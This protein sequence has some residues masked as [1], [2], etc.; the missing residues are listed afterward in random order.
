MTEQQINHAIAEACG[1]KPKRQTKLT[2]TGHFK[3]SYENPPDYCSDLNAMHD[4][5]KVLNTIEQGYYWDHL[6]DL[7]DEGFDQLHATAHQ[8]AE[9]F[10]LTLGKWS[11]TNKDFLSVHPTTEES[12][13]VQNVGWPP[14]KT[15]C[16]KMNADGKWEEV[17]W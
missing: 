6:K 11:A 8:R 2:R 13:A 15:R 4:A 9:A 5:E 14:P 3:V 16:S 17:Q 12:S 7:T 1:W 10:L